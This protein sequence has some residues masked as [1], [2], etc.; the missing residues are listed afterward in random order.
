MKKRTFLLECLF[1]HIRQGYKIRRQWWSWV[2]RHI[3]IRFK[4]EDLWVG[5]YWR[6]LSPRIFNSVGPDI[7]SVKQ[8]FICI[9]P[10]FPIC[11]TFG[12]VD[13]EVGKR[14]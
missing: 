7:L 1:Y 11:L 14:E 3:S 6:Q 12:E 9:V 4:K 13:K 10:M 8:V 2:Q 5:V